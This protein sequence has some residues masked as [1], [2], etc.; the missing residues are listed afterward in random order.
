M[1][2]HVRAFSVDTGRAQLIPGADFMAFPG[3]TY[4]VV[5]A[6]GNVDDAGRHDIL[7]GAGPGYDNYALV[8]GWRY[9]SSQVTLIPGLDFSAFNQPDYRFGVNLAIGW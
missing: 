2:S 7:T 4:G 3:L 5:V 1:G 6:A 8:K 9:E